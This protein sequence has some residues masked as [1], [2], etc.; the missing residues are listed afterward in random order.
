MDAKPISLLDRIAT[1]PARGQC[2]TAR[3]VTH[4]TGLFTYQN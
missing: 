1:A 3:L 2:F 4:P